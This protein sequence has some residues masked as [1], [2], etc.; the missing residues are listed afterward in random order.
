MIY[1]TKSNIKQILH[2]R[3]KKKTLCHERPRNSAR[4][5]ARSR[6]AHA[7]AARAI[8]LLARSLT[9]G[10]RPSDPSS[11]SRRSSGEPKHAVGELPASAVGRASFPSFTRTH[12]HPFRTLSHPLTPM[13]ASMADSN[14]GHAT[15]G[16][17]KWIEH[18][19]RGAQAP[20]AHRDFEELLS[21]VREGRRRAGHGKCSRQR[22]RPELEENS[23]GRSSGW[24]ELEVRGS[25]GS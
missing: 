15:A 1:Y 23:S 4:R 19:P 18:K 8:P 21:S 2:K 13:A 22:F 17:Y 10:S 14:L 25:G 9:G 6:S 16:C 24:L 20:V 5:P 7:C 11:S 12:W 3:K